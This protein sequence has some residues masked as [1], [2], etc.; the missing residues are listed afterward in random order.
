MSNKPRPSVP[1]LHISWTPLGTITP[2]HYHSEMNFFLI[3]VPKT[4]LAMGPTS[5]S[6][7]AGSGFVKSALNLW[8]AFLWWQ[9]GW[10][11]KYS[12]FSA[13]TFPL[14]RLMIKP[15]CLKLE[16]LFLDSQPL[17]L[18]PG[19]LSCHFYARL[20]ELKIWRREGSREIVAFQY[21]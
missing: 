5:T 19:I 11:R 18:N 16:L 14:L 20:R 2:M 15:Q 17:F 6:D 10:G 4:S 7:K 21:L 9:A 13:N 3:S 1:H 8:G 12:F